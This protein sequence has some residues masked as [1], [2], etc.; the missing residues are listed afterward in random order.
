MRTMTYKKTHKTLI[1][2][3]IKLFSV[4]LL[5]AAI[6]A[7]GS[8]S[9]GKSSED[10][11]SDTEA[12]VITLYGNE[13]VEVQL[14]SDY[15]DL[16]AAATD[17]VDGTVPVTMSGT[18]DTT[19][20][21]V[22]VLTYTATDA[23][24]NEA[25]AT[26]TVNVVAS[27]TEAPVITLYGNETVEVQINS[28]YTDL[29]ATATDD[30]DGTVPVTMSGTVDTAN[31][32]AYVL[33][34]TATDAAGNEATATRTVNVVASVTDATPP[35]ITL[36][37]N[38]IITIVV[39]E[40]F[41]DPGAT[42]ADAVDGTLMVTTSGTVDVSAIGRYTL[43]YTAT[44]AAGNTGSKIRTINVLTAP[45]TTPPVITLTGAAEITI[46][47]GTAFTDPGATATDNIDDSVTINV[48]GSVN[49]SAVGTYTLSYSATDSSDND[50]TVV[51]RTVI[52]ADL[53]APVIT[54]TGDAVMTVDLDSVFTDPGAT[55]TDNLDSTVTVNTTGTVN[56][57]AVGTY[58]INYSAA[59]AAGNAATVVSRTVTV[60]DISAPVITLTGNAV[61]ELDQGDV[62]TDPGATANDAVDGPITPVVSGS[63]DTSTIGTYTLTYTAIDV[64]GNEATKTRTINVNPPDIT[65]PVITLNGDNIINLFVHN[66]FIDPGATALDA[67]DGV[68]VVNIT[69]DTVDTN[70]AGI[71][72]L[73]YTATDTSGN[74]A[75]TTRTVSVGQ[76]SKLNDTG[77]TIA[78]WVIYDPNGDTSGNNPDCSTG[79]TN[80]SNVLEAQDCSHG[81][82]ADTSLVKTGA[83]DVGF[84]FTKLDAAGDP[85]AAN[86]AT[87]SCVKDNYSNLIWEVKTTSG[88]HNTD[89]QYNWH[90]T[91]SNT[92]GGHNGFENG[93]DNI[94]DGYLAGDTAS[95]CN[96]QAFVARVNAAG[97]CGASDWR[98]PTRADL[99]SIVHYG[100]ASPSP[101]IDED[102]F[103]NTSSN[104]D[105]WTSTTYSDT[106]NYRSWS[107]EFGE[108]SDGISPRNEEYKIRLV[109]DVK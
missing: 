15:T 68:V 62:F 46:D 90:N 72:T 32:G 67:R 19:N 30:V 89:D 21:G 80:E 13:T 42:A 79:H 6:A 102:Y 18:V 64:A 57:S 77:I 25:T 33:T 85:L 20:I 16:S 92:N 36:N 109:R 104:V 83:G 101:K 26:R 24:G 69:G 65:P 97:L 39:G 14:N 53:S 55:A 84:D 103:P 100:K 75:S 88:L 91:N 108:G 23:A 95:Y 99:R 87:W 37:G 10:S 56:T 61:I 17:D 81:R 7:C 5:V 35:V 50:A 45:D 96:T 43:V 22:Y 31:I 58:T 1:Q 86:A 4:G 74:E 44:D 98:I 47:A 60:A 9:S 52:V 105:Y 12:P 76:L 106:T 51:T 38:A 41:S 71:Y 28:D 93:G 63:V 8:S 29:S 70:T 73:I 49:T 34:Y 59:D 48:A 11:P 82:D 94:C 78:G 66:T 27:D 3:A 107:I 2:S 40:S 54:L